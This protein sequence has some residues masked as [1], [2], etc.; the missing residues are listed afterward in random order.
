[1]NTKESFDNYYEKINKN[2]YNGYSDKFE[3]Y[4]NNTFGD[5]WNFHLIFENEKYY[6]K[7]ILGKMENIKMLKKLDNNLKYYIKNRYESYGRDIIITNN[8]YNFF[9][10]KQ[11]NNMYIIQREIKSV[12]LNDRKYDYRIYVLILK[13]NNK[14][15]YYFYKYYILRFAREKYDNSNKIF[16]NLTNHH[17]YS[18]KDLDSNFYKIEYKNNDDYLKVLN[19]TKIVCKKISEYENEF[20][21][22]LN[23]NEFRIFGLDYLKENITNKFYVLELNTKPGVYYKDDNRDFIVKY[24]DFHKNIVFEL[25][26]LIY[27]NTSE[28]WISILS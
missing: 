14:I 6:P 8:P 24:C 2:L 1:M 19:L 3:K 21:D 18:L 17:I 23:E 15:I 11:M 9:L 4:M 20:K 25:N 26:N 5:K 22:L 10:K 7:S 13:K 27:K 16:S 12:M 28:K